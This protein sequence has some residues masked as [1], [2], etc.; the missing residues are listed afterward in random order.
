MDSTAAIRKSIDCHSIK[1][2]TLIIPNVNIL[3]YSY[4]LY[5]QRFKNISTVKGF[6]NEIKCVYVFLN[7]IS[8]KCF[9]IISCYCSLN[10]ICEEK[11]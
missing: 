11:T 2:L 1:R 5:K 10:M 4:R 9:I 6:Y 3:L 8:R 7:I